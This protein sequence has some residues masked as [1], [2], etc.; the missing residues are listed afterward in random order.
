LILWV[1]SFPRRGFLNW[2]R[3][4]KASELCKGMHSLIQW[5]LLWTEDART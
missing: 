1:V 4:E 5:V 2:V 3:V